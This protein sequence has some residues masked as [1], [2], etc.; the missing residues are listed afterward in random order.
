MI[1]LSNLLCDQTA[2][3]EKLR[4]GHASGDAK[5]TPKPVTVWAVTKA[6]N[7]KCVHCYASASD[8]PAPN[9]LTY[10]EGLA[11]LDDLKAFG[12]P[13]VLFSGGEPLARPDTPELIAHAVK[14][15]LP[16]TL[17]TNGLLIDDAMADRLANL[18]LK[19]VGISLDGMAA[20]HDKLRGQQGA[21]D[22]TLAAIDRCKQRGLK[23][24]VRFTVHALNH[25]ELDGLF[26]LCLTHN[27]DRL[28]MYHLAYAGRGQGLARV[29][30]SG[31]QTR[32][33][34][35]RLI[36]RTRQCHR[37]GRPLE[38][39]TVGNSADAAFVLLWVER[40][41]PDRLENVRKRL[42]G[43]AGNQSGNFIAAIDPLGQVHYDQF[44]WHYHCGNIRQQP[45]SAIW[46]N[47]TDQRLKILRD[48][49]Q[50]LPQRCQSCQ[51]LG[52][53][54]GNLR[55]RAEQATGDWMG[56]DPACYLRAEE[57][58]ALAPTP[59][60]L[61]ESFSSMNQPFTD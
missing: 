3:N 40:H 24:G 9:E 21:F 61:V 15:G 49:T 38:V 52:V 41:M 29:D 1:S 26:D 44:S 35:E 12:V 11:L 34:M 28:C 14:I 22:Q 53:C 36:N 37:A 7:L 19:Y 47:P 32:L 45:F 60:E 59:A 50:Y 57:I 25:T 27:V 13:A 20:T 56:I 46:G 51:Y 16:A 58:E 8:N 2:G 6:C 30:L 54:N 48:R 18:G 5:R 4:Y 33:V 43:T 39:L 55:T 10:A 31:P 17:S 23:V 42:E